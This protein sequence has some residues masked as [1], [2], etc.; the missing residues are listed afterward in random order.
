MLL[1]FFF[2]LSLSLLLLN[3]NQGDNYDTRNLRIPAAEFRIHQAPQ[4]LSF[5]QEIQSKVNQDLT[6]TSEC[7]SI[8]KKNDME[9]SSLR[10]SKVD[11]DLLDSQTIRDIV[12]EGFKVRQLLLEKLKTLNLKS[13]TG[14]R[15][16]AASQRLFFTLRSMED[17]FVETDFLTKGNEGANIRP[18]EGSGPIIQKNSK[19][20]Y[21][22]SFKD[23]KSGDIILSRSN[24]FSTGLL[25]YQGEVPGN[26]SNLGFVFKN[27]SGEISILETN[28]ET[29][30]IIIPIQEYLEQKR[31]RLVL[32]RFQDET[33]SSKASQKLFEKVS[34]A[35]EEDEVV[36]FDFL[37]DINEVNEI[38]PL[39]ML[40][41]AFK[42]TSS[43]A[44]DLPLY[45]AKFLKELAPF[46][47]QLGLSVEE[48]DLKNLETFSLNDLEFDPRI[49]LVLEWKDPLS[50]KD[51]RVKDLVLLKIY[52]WMRTKGYNFNPSLLTKFKGSISWFLRRVPLVS[53]KFEKKFPLNMT[54]E[55]RN[56]FM[57]IEELGEKLQIKIDEIAG[58]ALSPLSPL[59]I[60][61][62][63]EDYRYQDE[64]KYSKFKQF[65]DRAEVTKL[66]SSSVQIDAQSISKHRPDFHLLFHP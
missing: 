41:L 51:N 27:S 28:F 62:L 9:L 10:G 5:L 19:F 55:Q 53:L 18:F 66:L 23:L 61:E 60:L 38:F 13:P 36:P 12:D 11:M 64:L 7:N 6:N 50:V 8:I 15:C 2:G 42:E 34:L 45:K 65:K 16:L 52:D 32:Y 26:L 3:L 17:Y 56:L 35:I 24:S 58:S 46:W 29:G 57:G 39:E 49:E 48:D 30:L 54:T 4:L 22:S 59:E 33:L 63:L 25:A 31:T 40:H 14:R 43:G 21:F 20:S 37:S 1:F 44:V 47:K